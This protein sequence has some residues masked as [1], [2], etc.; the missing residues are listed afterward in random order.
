MRNPHSADQVEVERPRKIHP[1]PS[2]PGDTR[3]LSR[4]SIDERTAIAQEIQAEQPA[5]R[6][7][8]ATKKS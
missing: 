1:V 8:K 5:P 3:Y 2:W 4:L 7:R 6:R